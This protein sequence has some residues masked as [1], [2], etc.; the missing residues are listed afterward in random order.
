MFCGQCGAQLAVDSAF[1][2]RCG[3]RR[4][5]ALAAAGH[6]PFGGGRIDWT[7]RDVLFGVLWFLALFLLLPIPFVIPFLAFGEE[8]GEYLGAALI[9]G[10][11][12]EV[13]L[14]AVAAWFTF[15]KYGG[16]WERL[17]IAAPR[18]Q[19][20]AWAG[21]AV[22]A[23]FA[24]A[25]LYTVLIEVFDIDALRSERDDQLPDEVLDNGALLAIAGVV[26]IA[27][28][29]VCEELFF[30]GF[31]LPGMLRAWGAAIAIAASALVF[32][33]AHIGPNLHK[34]LVPIFII[35]AVFGFAYYRSGNILSTILAHLLFNTIS[36]AALAMSDPEDAE[37]V[38]AV[39][40][41]V[42]GR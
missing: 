14:I 39:L 26:V 37:A 25:S 18:W 22:I 5:G 4:D 7:L 33:A 21:G 38:A 19:T 17:G 40:A 12:S 35:G 23:A 11:G 42:I 41:G 36:F 24:L 34:T 1:C 28:A 8:S 31:V 10:A 13:G 2:G 30:R 32:S 20:L 6:P 27:F 15:R 29:P 16:S 9:A 3:A